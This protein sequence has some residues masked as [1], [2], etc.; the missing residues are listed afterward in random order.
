MREPARN[1]LDYAKRDL[2]AAEQLVSQ[3]DL[4]ALAAFHCRQCISILEGTA[5]AP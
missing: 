3:V 4:T 5:R 1:W 2:Q